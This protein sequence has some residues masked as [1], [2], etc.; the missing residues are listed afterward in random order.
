MESPSQI[1]GEVDEACLDM[2][3]DEIEKY[4]SQQSQL[5][6][7]QIRHIFV[8]FWSSGIFFQM[9]SMPVEHKASGKNKEH[10]EDR[11]C[12]R[13]DEEQRRFFLQENL[14]PEKI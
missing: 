6:S 9:F 13:I 11:L 1:V 4:Q 7:K 3:E 14:I 10:A 5:F 12:G 8:I 2:D